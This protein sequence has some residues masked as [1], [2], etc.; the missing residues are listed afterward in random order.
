MPHSCKQIMNPAPHPLTFFAA[1]CKLFSYKVFFSPLSK[2]QAAG[3]LRVSRLFC[4]Y[5]RI[6]CHNFAGG[7]LPDGPNRA[8]TR[9]HALRR[10]RCPHRP[11]PPNFLFSFC[12]GGR[13]RPAVRYPPRHRGG[14]RTRR[15]TQSFLHFR[16]GGRP[17]PPA[18]LAPCFM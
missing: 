12:R 9:S 8:C 18:G 16:R 7:G 14:V 2:K 1:D 3:P 15:L 6:S 10:G 17:C 13:P 11:A 5:R 4:F